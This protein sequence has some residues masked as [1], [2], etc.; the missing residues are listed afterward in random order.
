MFFAVCD[1]Q[2]CDS[3]LKL[4]IQDAG[5]TSEA[6]ETAEAAGWCIAGDV[7]PVCWCPEC[8]AETTSRD[9]SLETV[10]PRRRKS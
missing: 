1:S 6:I 3:K 9:E 2:G 10:R 4:E 8:V 5:D 7:E